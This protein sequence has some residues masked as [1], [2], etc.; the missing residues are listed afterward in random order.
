MLYYKVPYQVIVNSRVLAEPVFIISSLKALSNQQIKER[1][2]AWR[3]SEYPGQIPLTIIFK[4]LP[5]QIT[6]QQYNILLADDSL[7]EHD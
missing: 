1:I 6:E 2:T 3:K 5:S 4:E 7:S